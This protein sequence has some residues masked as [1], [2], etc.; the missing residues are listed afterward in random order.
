M[1]SVPNAL[2]KLCRITAL[3][4]VLAAFACLGCE[5]GD[6]D[7][8]KWDGVE[9]LTPS[10]DVQVETPKPGEGPRAGGVFRFPGYFALIA[11]P[12]YVEYF[13][14]LLVSELYSGLTTITGDAS[15]YVQPDLADRWSVR[16]DGLVYEFVLKRDLKFSDGSP[17]KSEDFKWSWERA[18]DPAHESHRAV[19]VFG[20]IVGADAVIQGIAK[21][22]SGVTVIDDRMLQVK[23][24]VPRADF[25]ALLA[26]PVAVVLKR[27]NVE[28]WGYHVAGFWSNP[29]ILPLTMKELPVGTGP[30]KLIEFDASDQAV[31]A[32]NDHYHGRAS[33]LDG[34]DFA[35]RLESNYYELNAHGFNR[36]QFDIMFFD[37]DDPSRYELTDL[38]GI[39]GKSHYIDTPQETRFFAFNTTIEP[40]DDEHFRRALVMAS[41]V[42]LLTEQRLNVDVAGGILPPDMP[43]YDST[44]SAVRNDPKGA[45]TELAASRY[46]GILTDID[47]HFI[48]TTWGWSERE[49]DGLAKEWGA[50]LGVNLLYSSVYPDQFVEISDNNGV[51]MSF[52]QIV[53]GY[54]DPHTVLRVFGSMFGASQGSPILSATRQMLGVASSELDPALRIKR[55]S[56]L[57][58][59][60][61]EKALALPFEWLRGGYFVVVK[62][63]V[64][65]LNTPKYGGSVFQD[66]WLDETAPE[67]T[68]SDLR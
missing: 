64:H 45:A 62:P 2:V 34:V 30:F 33:Y 25:P 46:A 21:E 48:D 16:E 12:A 13:D 66:V 19:D 42:D 9:Y 5:K 54:P 44:L 58:R 39:G 50:A 55:Y 47:L 11:D 63:W 53:P 59:F 60:V 26:D 57:E 8:T 52:F 41:Y 51:E 37:E 7:V 35:M 22:I 31:I 56:D 38:Q 36:D 49:I 6:D 40:Y 17:V 43:G 4:A 18:L 1:N 23:L 32:R 68:L 15:S 65:D 28:N 14:P 29:Q 10:A 3:I 24:D 20:D 27:A 61:L 67:R